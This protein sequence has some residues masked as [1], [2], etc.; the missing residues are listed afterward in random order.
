MTLI[1]FPWAPDR[2]RVNDVPLDP[3]ACGRTERVAQSFPFLETLRPL[4][5]REPPFDKLTAL[6]KSKGRV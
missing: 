5:E 4:L 3:S 2:I 6:P 1:S